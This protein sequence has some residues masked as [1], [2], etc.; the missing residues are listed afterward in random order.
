MGAPQ[1]RLRSLAMHLRK[2]GHEVEV[3][4]AMPN[5]PT[6][7]VFQGYGGCYMQEEMDGVTLHRSWLVPSK[8]RSIS[9]RTLS[10][11]SFCLS[12]FVTGLIK[13]R[14]AD[15]I[16]TESPPLFLAGAGWLLARLKGA[17]WIMNV[18]DLWPD[19]A[20]D[21][22][23]F[24]ETSL[25]YRMLAAH[26]RSLYR[27]AWLVTGQS[28][29]IVAEIGMQA[30]KAK[31]YH[32]SNGVD[33][34]SFGPRLRDAGIRKKYLKDGEAGFVYAGLHGIFQGLEQIIEAAEIL[35]NKPIRFVLIGDGPEKESLMQVARE[36]G[37]LNVD[38][39]PPVSHAEMPALLAS[40]DVAVITLKTAIKGAV[41]SKI[42]EAMG[43]GIAI[44][45]AAEG[46]PARIV[47]ESNAGIA[48]P[49]GDAEALAEAALRLALDPALRARLGAAGREAVEANYSRVKIAESFEQKLKGNF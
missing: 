25:P 18:S 30:P 1:A 13:V 46:E 42:Y 26:A 32:L 5:Y 48:V 49:P 45:L 47:A 9:H 8:K 10:Y 2:M 15:V 44:L 4:T 34:A 36:K 37:L 20:K 19:F 29:G 21:T 24:K 3:L 7:K 40:M 12:S 22:G 27:A 39:Y 6:G 41:P 23:M 28:Q 11:L 38:F 31:T 35:R 43:S 17:R 14:K 16:M 33:I